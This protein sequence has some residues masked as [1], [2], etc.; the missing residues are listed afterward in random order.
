MM[1]LSMVKMRKFSKIFVLF[2]L[3]LGNSCVYAQIPSD[4][5]RI[6]SSQITDAQLMQ[7]VQQAQSSGMGEAELMAEFQKKGLPDAELQ[8]L[9]VRLKGLIG[10]SQ[11]VEPS[12][13]GS[14][15]KVQSNKRSYKGD[16]SQFKIPE[17][18]SRVFGSELFSGL[19][20]LFVPNLKL[21]TPKGY[22]IGPE[23]EL[24]LDIYGN[25]ISSQKLMVS[26]D[27]LINVKYAGPVNVSGMSIEAAAGV[28]KSRLTKF[29]PALSSGQT[30]LQLVLGSIRSIQVTVIG[31]VKKPGTITLPSIA[32]LFNALYASGGPMDNGSFRNISLLRN[33][34]V[35]ATADLYDFILK[36]DQSSNLALRDNDVIRIPFAQKQVS[37]DGELNRKGIFEVKDNE[38]LHEALEFAGGF[39][40]NAFKGRITG[41]RFTDVEKKIIDVAKDNFKH[42]NFVHGDSLYVDSVINRFEN[43]VY[44]TGAVFKP[45]A[46]SIENGIDV[47]ELIAKAQGIKED[48]FTG[49]ANMVRLRNDMT[50][51]YKSFNLKNIL[52]GTE[53]IQMKKED[54]IHVVSIL[55]LRDSTTITVLGP[56]KKPGDFRYEDSLTLQAVIL[57]A[58][59]FMENATPSRI[60]IGRRKKDINLGTKGAPTSEVIQVNIDKDLG[61]IGT[62]IYLKPFDVIS[63]KADPAKVKQISVK[64]SG[65]ILY[66]GTYTLENPE[67]RLS[68]IVKRAGGLLPYADINGAKLVRKKEKLDTAQIKRLALSAVKSS[69]DSKYADTATSM[70]TRELTSLTTDVALDLAKIIARPNS[71]DDLT[72]Q[73]GDELIIPRFNNTVSVGGEVLKPVTVQ[74]EPGKGFVSYLS[75]AGGFTRNAYKTRAFVVYPNGRSAKSYSFLGIRSYPKVTPGSSIFVPIKP[76]SNSFDP[77]KAG[78]LVSAFSAIMTAVVLFF[79]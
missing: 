35:I 70:S 55:E 74:Y 63:V 33:N 17:K 18:P 73:D 61:Q 51:E 64:V 69:S 19:D 31:A 76:E 20:P 16:F 2:L 7:F 23:D 29:Y 54:S 30:K 36:G 50:K 32:T 12:V 42:F 78:I 43:R 46:Y 66:A 77:A 79:R 11:A 68:S 40:S 10:S 48:A 72:L 58:G 67:E 26:P 15:S 28:L 41:T 75:A 25:N 59:G 44:I 47:R 39:K 24:Q 13:D 65:E 45:G 4:L 60:E 5:S 56:V 34:K 62:D 38:S 37:L 57:Q 49:R 3:L 21:A 8:A 6:K 14:G 27:G 22:V 9:A 53:T 1:K 71:E 52:N